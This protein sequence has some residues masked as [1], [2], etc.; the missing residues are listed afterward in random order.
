MS[1][2]TVVIAAVIGCTLAGSTLSAQEPGA[3]PTPRKAR[4][5]LIAPSGVL[6]P[7]GDQ[8]DAIKRANLSAVQIN[9]I[10]KPMLAITTMSGWARSRDVAT[11]GS[12][13]L[14]VFTYDVG[15]ELR[16]PQV[17]S[18]KGMTFSAFAGLGAGGRS[19]N[20]RKLDVEATHNLSAYGSVGGEIGIR[21]VRVRLEARDYVSE[22]K[23]LVGAGESRTGNDVVVMAGL[24]LV[25]R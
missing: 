19:Y 5:E 6:L 3:Q 2:N 24:R 9:F 23:P 16:V 18:G 4:W 11:P 12:P 14:D 10:A 20:Y 21:R 22:F 8:R 1:I 15:A 25:S 7:T 13:K 17:A